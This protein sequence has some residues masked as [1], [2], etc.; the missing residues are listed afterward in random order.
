MRH[1]E[2]C[3]TVVTGHVQP[4]SASLSAATA[5]LVAAAASSAAATSSEGFSTPLSSLET[6]QADPSFVESAVQ[7]VLDEVRTKL[8]LLA[9]QMRVLML[10]GD[11]GVGKS[12]VAKHV[13]LKYFGQHKE[14]GS[15]QLQALT[16][17]G[18]RKYN[19]RSAFLLD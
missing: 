2:Q 16:F 5:Y 9:Q 19:R 10:H 7:P 15:M 11:T 12:A 17:S 1:S 13:A 8:E 14:V 18:A 6:E 4:D 3:L